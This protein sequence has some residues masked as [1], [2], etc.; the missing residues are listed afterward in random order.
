[1][2][3]YVT[4]MKFT[5]QGIKGVKGTVDRTRQNRAAIEKAGGRMS[6]I[7][8][9]QGEYDLVAIT[10]WPDEETATAFLIQLGMSGNVRSETLRAF[11]ESAMQRILAK[12]P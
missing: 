4:L 12:V 2:P 1:M 3:T 5:D 7:Y 11:D 6:S 10:D 8:W 9:T